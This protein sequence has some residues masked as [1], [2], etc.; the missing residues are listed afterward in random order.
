MPKWTKKEEKYVE[1]HYMDMT[2]E[3][4]AL[5]LNHSQCAVKTK[6]Q[7][8]GLEKSP[9]KFQAIPLE[10]RFWEKVDKSGSCW[11]WTGSLRTNGYGEIW[12]E[13]RNHQAHRV[14][15]MLFNGPIPEDMQVCHRCDV[16]ACVRPDHLF[17]GTQVDNMVDCSEK[18]RINTEVKA[19]GEAHGS[20]KLTASEVT[21]IREKYSTGSYTQREIGQEYGVTQTTIG[22]V[23]RHETWTHLGE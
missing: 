12:Y 20:S 13:G 23:V 19:L 1:D 21:E 11:L 16:R 3:E 8:M 15:W 9:A 6:R 5:V 4:L 22:H 2:D 17:L 14:S 18:G 10:E 7:R